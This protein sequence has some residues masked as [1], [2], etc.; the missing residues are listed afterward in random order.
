MM[1]RGFSGRQTDE[2]CSFVK[3]DVSFILCTECNFTWFVK[4]FTYKALMDPVQIGMIRTV[5]FAKKD[6]LLF[7]GKASD[8]DNGDE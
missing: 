1:E 7:R 6:P 5:R 3:C 4:V 8:D 2:E